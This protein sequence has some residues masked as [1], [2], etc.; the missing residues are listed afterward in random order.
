MKKQG[1]INLLAIL[2]FIWFAAAVLFKAAHQPLSYDDSYNA[3]VASNFAAG[4]GWVTDYHVLV[5]F[6]STITTGPSLLLPAAALVKVFGPQLWV[7]SIA[8]AL[9]MVFMVLLCGVLLRRVMSD[10]ECFLGVTVVSLFSLSLY[11]QIIWAQ[12]IG[13]GFAALTLIAVILLLV[14]SSEE[15]VGWPF[16]LAAGA[17]FAVALL[18]KLYA[19]IAIMGMV[20]ALFVRAIVAHLSR[21]ESVLH[22]LKIAGV[23]SAGAIAMLA[24]WQFYKY[25][26]MGEL[27]AE[28]QVSRELFSEMFFRNFGSGIEALSEADS[29]FAHFSAVSQKSFAGLVNYLQIGPWWATYF[30]LFMIALPFVVGAGLLLWRRLNSYALTLLLLSA[31]ASAH[32]AWYIFISSGDPRY[33]RISMV[34]TCILIASLLS[35]RLRISALAALL[36][37]G[38]VLLPSLKREALADLLLFD[39]NSEQLAVQGRFVRASENI[40]SGEVLVGCGWV[41]SRVVD[42]AAPTNNG[43]AD[44]V[45]LLRDSLENAGYSAAEKAPLAEGQREK[46]VELPR[47]LNIRL[48]MNLGEW[49]FAKRRQ[50]CPIAEYLET[51]CDRTAFQEGFYAVKTC[52]ISSVPEKVATA[53]MASEPIHLSGSS[54]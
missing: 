23:F 9:S 50:L 26:A 20:F 2:L 47:P 13:D 12:L 52:S 17:L 43:L 18:A 53:V 27:S 46:N 32:W 14:K 41:V 31:G 6:N 51:V 39:G 1:C 25:Q 38:I 4:A 44:V 24:P 16:A 45:L 15:R 22:A 5:P 11:D 10:D 3:A 21:E 34:L 42:Y 30:A 54:W 8:N 28:L 19:V 7:P 37:I 36:A 29:L 48:P 49:A 40:S 35:F 33:V